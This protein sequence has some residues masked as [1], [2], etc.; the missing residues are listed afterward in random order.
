MVSVAAGPVVVVPSRRSRRSSRGSRTRAPPAPA[1]PSSTGTIQRRRALIRLSVGEGAGQ[2]NGPLPAYGEHDGNRSDT[3]NRA[4]RCDP[5][6]RSAR[7]RAERPCA[8]S[9]VPACAAATTT[10]LRAADPRPA[11]DAVGDGRGRDVASFRKKAPAAPPRTEHSV[12][13]SVRAAARSASP[14]TWRPRVRSTRPIDVYHAVRSELQRVGCAAHRLPRR[15]VAQLQRLQERAVR[16]PRGRAAG[17]SQLA[18]VHARGVPAHARRGAARAPGYPRAAPAVSVDRIQN[19]NAAYSVVLRSGVSY[20]VNLANETGRSVRERRAVRDPGRARSKKAS[21]RAAPAL[22]RLRPV[23]SRA[24]A[25]EACYSHRVDAADILQA[26]AALPPRRSRPP[27]PPKRRPGL[28]SATTAARGAA[29]RQRRPRAAPV[30]H[31]RPRAHSNLT[32][33]LRAP[34]S[35][36]FNLQLRNVN[37]QVIECA[38]GGSGPQTLTKQLR[39]GR[40]Y[41]VVSVHDATAGNYTLERAVADDHRRRTSPSGPP[42]R[43]PGS[44]WGWTSRSAPSVSGPVTVD[45]ER[46]DPVFGW[47]FYRQETGLA[48]GRAR[49][50][51]LRPARGR[52]LAR[53]RPLRRH[54]ARRA[55]AAAGFAYLLVS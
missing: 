46:F 33:R 10:R 27:A 13:Y 8:R 23:H 50:A 36:D 51:A 25:R 40:Y 4:G 17:A 49:D 24:Q 21:P 32:L 38:C 54:A 2:E 48:I 3:G 30:S 7:A 28:R 20:L 43:V 44:Q 5:R 16:D 12:W 22:R 42:R 9:G 1:R 31:R 15:G 11:G 29:R 39:P 6:S 14:S 19:I 47:Q 41:A 34:S 52:P 18:G 55:P 37:G 35:A 45:I 53:E 26:G